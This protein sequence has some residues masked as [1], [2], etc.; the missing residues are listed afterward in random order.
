VPEITLC[1]ARFGVVGAFASAAALDAVRAPAGVRSCRVA[2]DEVALVCAPGET[3]ALLAAV[4]TQLTAA[5]AHGFV[6]DLSEGWT[7]FSLRGDVARA[8]S[9]LSELALPEAGG[10]VQGDVLR[11]PVRVLA[12]AEHLDLLV[13]SPWGAYLHDEL[14]ES[15]RALE[16]RDAS[17]AP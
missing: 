5:D 1:N 13:P 12:A 8:F 7:G 9:Y 3:A 4:A 11:V 14:L 15:L 6:L 16:V 17:E 2:P 10:F